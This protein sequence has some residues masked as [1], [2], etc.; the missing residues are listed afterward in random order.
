MDLITSIV[1]VHEQVAKV[2]VAGSKASDA[3]EATIGG[4]AGDEKRKAASDAAHVQWKVA[5]L[6]YRIAR[7]HA[8][9]G[10]DKPDAARVHDVEDKVLAG[11]ERNPAT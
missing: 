9:I 11:D 10:A 3:R 8:Q 2:R 7:E 1:D 5:V 4:T 6:P